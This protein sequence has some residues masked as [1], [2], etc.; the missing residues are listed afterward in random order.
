M[1]LASTS[2]PLARLLLD[3]TAA[4]AHIRAREPRTDTMSIILAAGALAWGADWDWREEDWGLQGSRGLVPSGVVGDGDIKAV[5]PGSQSRPRTAPLAYASET[6]FVEAG[7]TDDVPVGRLSDTLR[8]CTASPPLSAPP[9]PSP[10]PPDP[11]SPVTKARTPVPPSSEP[12]AIPSP[13]PRCGLSLGPIVRS[14]LSTPQGMLPAPGT[15]AWSEPKQP[16]DDVSPPAQTLLEPLSPSPPPPFAAPAMSAVPVATAGP[17]LRCAASTAPETVSARGDPNFERAMELISAGRPLDRRSLDAFRLGS[18]ALRLDQLSASP[19]PGHRARSWEYPPEP[20]GPRPD[21]PE[22]ILR[23]YAQTYLPVMDSDSLRWAPRLPMFR[24]SL[25]GSRGPPDS[26]CTKDVI[27]SLVRGKVCTKEYSLDLVHAFLHL[28][29]GVYDGLVGPVP[30]TAGDPN[31]HRLWVDGS[32]LRVGGADEDTHQH[33]KSGSSADSESS[34]WPEAESNFFLF[35]F[36]IAD[37]HRPWV[38][39]LAKAN[40]TASLSVLPSGTSAC[41]R[42][43]STRVTDVRLVVGQSRTRQDYTWTES[44]LARVSSVSRF[45]NKHSLTQQVQSRIT[46]IL[47]GPTI[48][49]GAMVKTVCLPKRVS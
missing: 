36:Q 20:A 5:N 14:D 47:C 28:V 49:S 24:H 16:R 2:A 42:D 17:G 10:E 19:V 22:S 12:P 43:R 39:C 18:R 40:R 35:L 44:I 45:Q 3:W 46:E 32:I 6:P 31:I 11:A 15:T 7:D 38:L 21:D 25:P 30:D 29:S 26:V 1:H 33:V 48:T 13:H 8:A 9:L 41:D 37:H 23:E 34:A 4:V 27:G